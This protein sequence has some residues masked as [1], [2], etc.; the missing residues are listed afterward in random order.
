MNPLMYSTGV[1]I[2]TPSEPC[3]A[4]M[5]TQTPCNYLVIGGKRRY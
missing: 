3:D 2:A 5:G 1:E 4:V